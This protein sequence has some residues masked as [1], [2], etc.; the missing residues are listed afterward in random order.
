MATYWK[1]LP[2]FVVSVVR[3]WITLYI[4][5][6]PSREARGCRKWHCVAI[7]ASLFLHIIYFVS[8]LSIL[9]LMVPDT[10]QEPRGDMGG[11]LGYFVGSPGACRCWGTA[12]SP[13][14]AMQLIWVIWL[15][16]PRSLCL[17]PCNCFSWPVTSL[18]LCDHSLRRSFDRP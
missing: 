16:V 1:M 11:S 4:S 15:H 12:R 14:L 13:C 9:P 10:C 6:G 5:L 18:V 17:Y 2:G 3:N 8:K 7:T